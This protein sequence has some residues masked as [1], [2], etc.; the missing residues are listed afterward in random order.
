MSQRDRDI[1]RKICNALH[2]RRL[3]RPPKKSNQIDKGFM[4]EEW[5]FFGDK[6]LIINILIYIHTQKN[7]HIS[8]QPKYARRLHAY[9]VNDDS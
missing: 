3:R 2:A 9:P 1:Y 4:S 6:K 5:P 7:T 8:C